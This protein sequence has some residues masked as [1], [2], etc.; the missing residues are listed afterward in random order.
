[1]PYDRN[2]VARVPESRLLTA[3]L[4]WAPQLPWRAHPSDSM[5]VWSFFVREAAA[6]VAPKSRRAKRKHWLTERASQGPVAIPL[7]D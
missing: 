2:R 6:T 5:A 7:Q 1:M 4:D 3:L